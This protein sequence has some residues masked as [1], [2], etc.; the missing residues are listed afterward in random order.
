MNRGRWLEGV[1]IIGAAVIALWGIGSFGL[2]EP[3]ELRDTW[4]SERVFSWLGRSEWSARLGV[5]AA[6]L[7][8]GSLTYSML[9]VIGG[10]SAGLVGIAVLVSS[11]LF[12]LNARLAMGDAVGMAAQAFVGRSRTC[13]ERRPPA[14]RTPRPTLRGPRARHRGEHLGE[15]RSPRTVATA[16]RRWSVQSSVGR[17]R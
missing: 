9:R 17:T 8:L 13:R 5:V 11:P 2:W 14:A 3:W 4:M 12:L 6:G 15:R 10:G 7:V 16:A 1:V